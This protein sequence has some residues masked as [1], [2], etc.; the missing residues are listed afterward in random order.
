MSDFSENNRRDTDDLFSSLDLTEET[1]LTPSRPRER[2][3]TQRKKTVELNSASQT[4]DRHALKTAKTEKKKSKVKKIIFWSVLEVITLAAIFVY[5][6]FLRSWNLI[7]RPEVNENVI[8]N[9]NLSAEK[10]A[11]MEQGYWTFVVFGVDG[12]GASDLVSKGL[13]SDVVL[14]VS[15]NQDTGEIRMC[16]VFRDT[17][18]NI[19]DNNRYRKINQAYS[20]GGPE[21]ALAAIN[22]NLDLNIKNYVT[23]NWKAVADGINILGGIDGIDIS[24]AELYYINA[25]ITE[26]VKA[27]KIGSYQLKST[28]VQ[29]LDGVQAVAYGRLRLMDN[30]Y[31][32]TERQKKVI[33]A[34]FDKAKQSSFSVLNN[35]MVVCF[36]EVA[37]NINFNTV[38]A[39]AQNITKYYISESGGF[40]WQRSESSAGSL[41]DVVVP[42][43]LESNVRYLHEFLFGDSDYEPSQAVLSYSNTIKEKTGIYKEG[44]VVE[45][46]RTD[47]GLISSP[48][49]PAETAKAAEESHGDD[50]ENETDEEGNTVEKATIGVDED[51]NLI[52]PTNAEGETVIPKDSHGNPIYPTDEEGETIYPTDEDGNPLIPETRPHDLNPEGADHPGEDS[53]GDDTPGG[54][55]GPGGA[56][57]PGS[58]GRGNQETSGNTPGPG[59]KTTESESGNVGPGSGTIPETTTGGRE[60][61]APGGDLPNAEI[62]PGGTGGPGS[63]SSGNTA[64]NTTP[65]GNITPG[66]TLTPGGN[67]TP[68]GNDS[69]GSNTSGGSTSG[70]PGSGSGNTSGGD[71]GPGSSSGNTTPGGNTDGPGSSGSPQNAGGPGGGQSP[72]NAPIG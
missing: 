41:G 42:A 45:S 67:T 50:T 61:D 36:P 10:I 6:Y 65:G 44:Q 58:E 8:E 21:Q 1:S 39:M 9:H 57:G 29:H 46:V 15:V 55:L 48:K 2:R 56:T 37:T 38:V 3:G 11:Q 12:R 24:K 70:G 47:G 25:F 4:L 49:K 7:T 17:Y 26:T 40:P 13:N 5:G 64:G 19:S 72:E 28:G 16:S 63:E 22:K 27:T 51:G 60:Q 32:R 33:K 52:Y 30:D 18:L 71:Q 14:I 20:E 34:A 31:A 54:I 66:G 59:Q 68:G 69:P 53:H 23:F 43:T 35:I 62:I